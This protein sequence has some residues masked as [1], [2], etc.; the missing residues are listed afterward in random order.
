M[1]PE[2]ALAFRILV[3]VVLS[4]GVIYFVLIASTLREYGEMMDQAWHRRIIGWVNDTVAT[5]TYGSGYVPTTPVPL[6]DPPIRVTT[7]SKYQPQVESGFG[8]TLNLYSTDP[9][10]DSKSATRSAPSAHSHTRHG[11]NSSLRSPTPHAEFSFSNLVR[12]HDHEIGNKH[13]VIGSNLVSTDENLSRELK[14]PSSNASTPSPTSSPVPAPTPAHPLHLR[15]AIPDEVYHEIVTDPNLSQEPIEL[16]RLLSLSF[17]GDYPL[18]VPPSEDELNACHM[19]K[20]LWKELQTVSVTFLWVPL[21]PFNNKRQ[22][23]QLFWCP[24]HPEN[25]ARTLHEGFLLARSTNCPMRSVYGTRVKSVCV[26]L[27]LD[28][29]DSTTCRTQ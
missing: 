1:T 6:M 3:S 13:P 17:E 21:F 15:E 2:D 18:D 8:P 16:V 26:I 20:E 9:Y 14:I 28:C 25:I 24:P 29:E 22:D 10:P 4:L 7:Q 23:A 27:F 19:T 12:G 5:A 11:S